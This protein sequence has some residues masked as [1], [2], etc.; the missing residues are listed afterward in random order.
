[1]FKLF[2]KNLYVLYYIC[3]VLWAFLHLSLKSKLPVDQK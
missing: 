3:Y 1:M 2:E